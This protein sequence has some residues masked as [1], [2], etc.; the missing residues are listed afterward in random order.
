MSTDPLALPALLEEA[1]GFGTWLA[2]IGYDYSDFVVGGRSLVFTAQFAG[3]RL[4]LQT[5]PVPI[6]AGEVYFVSAILKLD[7]NTFQPRIEVVELEDDQETTV[8]VSELFL[9]DSDGS[10][11]IT[12]QQASN[13]VRISKAFVANSSSKYARIRFGGDNNSVAVAGSKVWFNGINIGFAPHRSFAHRSANYVVTGSASWRVINFNSDESLGA[14][15]NATN[16]YIEIKRPSPYSFNAGLT[17]QP[18][19]ANTTIKIRITRFF[20]STWTPVAYGS[21]AYTGS[22]ENHL[23]LSCHS[24]GL[25]DSA[26][27]PGSRFR[28][29]AFLP[30]GTVIGDSGATKTWFS[31][32]E[33][34]APG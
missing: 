29:E 14:E 21:Q 5:R 18:T 8:T 27:E 11:T 10:P 7:S 33:S 32:L 15:F 19:S 6:L 4:Q 28:V 31:V 30:A 17:F 13:F 9:P 24:I 16:N 20:S 25:P 23:N 2:G 1:P 3:S 26:V 12:T 34:D 22:G